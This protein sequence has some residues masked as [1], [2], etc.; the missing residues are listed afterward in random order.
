MVRVNSDVGL[1]I[2]GRPAPFATSGETAW[3]NI[4][5]RE[6]PEAGTDDHFSGIIFEFHLSSDLYT[7]KG[8]D[9]DN[10]VEPVFSVLINRKGYFGGRRP[11]VR[12]FL[13]RRVWGDTEGLKIELCKGNPP[14][15]W[16]GKGLILETIYSGPIPGSGS[17]SLLSEWLASQG[18]KPVSDRVGVFLSLP[19]KT[20]IGD[21]STGPVKRVI[22]SLYPVLGGKDAS[23]PEDWKIN[24]LLVVKKE[25]NG[26]EI[27]IWRI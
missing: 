17:F 6:I 27:K 20:N 1:W 21:I 7:R 3:R 23:S 18:L 13:A 15:I 12:W 9:L 25:I 22:D 8:Y 11:N 5:M 10:L 24:E 4:L 16:S 26:I 14:P 2:S 19:E